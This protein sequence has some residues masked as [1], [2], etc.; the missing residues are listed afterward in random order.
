MHA[1]SLLAVG[2]LALIG[3]LELQPAD[4]PP[5]TNVAVSH[6]YHVQPID[7]GRIFS[8]LR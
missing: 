5:K 1:I 8:G 2:A 6:M 7:I 3:F 4:S